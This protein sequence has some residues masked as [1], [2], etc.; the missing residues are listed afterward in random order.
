MTFIDSNVL[1]DVF[2]FDQ[3]W[4][5]WSR[6]R[7][8]EQTAT[9]DATI[10][11]VVLAELSPG[12]ET[13]ETLINLLDSFSIQIADFSEEAA[14]HSGRMFARYRRGRERSSTRRVLP[15]FMIGAHALSLGLP[16]LTR[17][18]DIYRRYFPEL[19]LITPE[20]H[21]G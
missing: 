17:D 9:G 20:T 7:I 1:I 2:E 13:L 3:T 8:E 12:Y 18:P 16:L 19:T 4:E 6:V 10:N 14:F 5:E 11:V 15:D 21:N